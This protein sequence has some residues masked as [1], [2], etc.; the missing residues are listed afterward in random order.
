MPDLVTAIVPIY[1][2]ENYLDAC[3]QSLLEQTYPHLEILLVDD[4]ATDASG[5]LCDDWAQKDQRIRAL[6]K[7]N[8]GLS[9]A[10][11][12]GIA[13]AKGDYLIFVDGD[14]R[15]KPTY[16]E[17][18]YQAISSQQADVAICSFELVDES[19]HPYQ[20]ELLDGPDGL[21]DG[22]QLLKRVLDA[23]GYK[24]VV[25]WN[26][27]YSRNIFEHLLFEKGKTYEDEYMNFRLFWN[28]S[29][30]VTLQEA[31][32]QY[33][34]R[35]D[36]ITTSQM[37]ADKLR[38]KTQMHEE[39]L[40]FYRQ[41]DSDLYYKAVQVYCNWLVTCFT[42]H[43]ALLAAKEKRDLQEQFRQMVKSLSQAAVRTPLGLQCQ[44]GLG[45]LSLSL[46][47]HVKRLVKQPSR[48]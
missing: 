48:K 26:K 21:K 7:P 30:V 8:G 34:C 22:R 25:A 3:V 17:K 45:Y 29:K 5:Q 23:D 4:G 36:S 43:R 13:R 31:L 47:G 37:T 2:V 35:P 19:Y 39:R 41:K 44:N 28:F 12:Y 16:V 32:Y 10:R 18:L 42:D 15:V 1:N 38:M 27:I 20:K 46:A 14:D 33:V 9:D 11:N 6:H 24:Y 40:A